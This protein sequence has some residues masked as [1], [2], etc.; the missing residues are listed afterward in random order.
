MYRSK[1]G[2]GGG[3][4]AL[5]LT[6]MALSLPSAALA[7]KV[8]DVIKTGES[9]MV[10]Q[11]ASQKR[12][13]GIAEER[14]SLEDEYRSVLRESDGLRL[15]L[16][17]LSAQLRSQQAEMDVVRNESREIERTNIEIL[18]LMN[19]MLETLEQF[20][21][22]D[23]PFLDQDRRERIHNLKTL[24]PRADV[25]VSEKYRR[26]I[27]AYQ[28]EVDYGRTIEAYRSELNGKVVD[29]LR[30]GRVALMYQTPD[31]S[32]TGYWDAQKKTWVQDSD[33]RRAVSDGLKIA[34][35]QSTPN[36]LIVPVLAAKK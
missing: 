17:Q 35:K 34:K 25:S 33:Y 8:S 26:I 7:A 24:M 16:Q 36:L 28:I 14:R 29:V 10:A 4:A 32:E 30:A 2:R 22:L 19:S 27:E 9:F 3:A 21:A 23:L 18:P 5:L 15:Y 1:V 31:G 12:V 20:V 11:I 13:D 6:A